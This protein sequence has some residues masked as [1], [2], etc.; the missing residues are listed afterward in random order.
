MGRFKLNI[1][2]KRKP[3]GKISSGGKFD[4]PMAARQ[5]QAAKD[6]AY[7]EIIDLTDG[8]IIEMKK[9]VNNGG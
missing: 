8:R 4:R 9:E 7:Y 6:A 3:K 2:E 1:Y 5:S